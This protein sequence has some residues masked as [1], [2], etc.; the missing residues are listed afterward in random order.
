MALVSVVVLDACVLY[1]APLRDLFMRLAIHGMIQ[2]KWS[3]KIHE[4]WMTAVLRERVDLTREKLQRT[5]ELM[6]KHAQG[7]LVSD[8]ERH[9]A[10]LTL[11]DVDDRHVLAT[12]IE[13]EADAIV[14]WNLADF[15]KS[16]LGSHCVEVW[17]PDNLV[18][19]LLAENQDLVIQI[20]REHRASLKNPPKSADDYLDTLAQQRLV[21]TVVAVR[22]SGGVL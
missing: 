6:D 10:R 2:A 1:P 13:W 9:M 17:T 12:A 22:K 3:E 7:S 15:P 20:M 11:P 5:R 14:T 8:Y 19:N 18:M 4:E 16:V 21:R